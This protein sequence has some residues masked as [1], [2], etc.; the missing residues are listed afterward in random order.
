MKIT[1]QAKT[2]SWQNAL[3][4]AVTDPAELLE[5]L[6]LDRAL[7][8]AAKRAAALFP[9][10]VPRRFVALMEKNN[11]ADPLLRQVLP[12]GAEI[13]EV[14]GYTADPLGEAKANPIPGL[15]HKY[16]GRVLLTFSGQCGINCRYC[17]RRAFPYAENNP[18]MAGWEKVLSYIQ[19]DTTIKEVIL[20][21]GDP[22]IATDAM[23]KTFREKLALIPHVQRLRLHSR[24][25][26][27]LPERITA[28]FI[29][30][31]SHPRLKTILVVHCNHPRE[32]AAD[33]KQA[34]QR[35]AAAGIVLLNQSVL[36][37]GVNDEI[38]TLV[39]LSEALFAAG[40]Q[41]YY[42]NV[43]D[44]VQGATHFDLNLTV[45]RQLH[46]GMIQRLSGYLVPKLV[47]EQ[48]SA[49]AKLPVEVRELF[50][51]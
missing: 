10:R 48:A 22:L 51:G 37:Q 43:L 39:T 13:A 4:N 11:L 40:I 36:L 35:L 28:D 45:A 41:P 46:W 12:L 31:I 6:Q 8:E 25:P 32:I 30:A 9:L 47:Q 23:L 33:V 42:L 38:E 24:M 7:L 44:K 50:T 3:M 26:I 2:N 20:S 34:M 5:L 16:Q 19:Q 15:L 49:P 18:G 27:V 29:A 1:S 21:G 14:A 17:F